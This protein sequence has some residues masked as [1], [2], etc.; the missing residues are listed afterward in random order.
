[1]EGGEVG[2]GC[3]RDVENAGDVAAPHTLKGDVRFKHPREAVHH[4]RGTPKEAG[5]VRR[6][7]KA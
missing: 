2:V 7:G 6:E 3:G 5:E 4:G 1:M